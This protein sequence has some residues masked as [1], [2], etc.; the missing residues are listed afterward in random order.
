MS[1]KSDGKH[2]EEVKRGA[3]STNP[4]NSAGMKGDISWLLCVLEKSITYVRVNRWAY[5]VIGIVVAATASMLIARIASVNPAFPIV[6][7]TLVFIGMFALR[8]FPNDRNIWSVNFAR[9][10]L[11]ISVLIAIIVLIGLAVTA[12]VVLVVRSSTSDRATEVPTRLKW[13]AEN[14]SAQE[15]LLPG[16]AI[17]TVRLDA[18]AERAGEPQNATISFSIISNACNWVVLE[19]DNLV[20]TVP[21]RFADLQNSCDVVV[22]AA[23][24]LPSGAVIT[25][26]PLTIT[27]SPRPPLIADLTVGTHHACALFRNGAVQCWGGLGGSYGSLA[28]PEGLIAKKIVAGYYSVCAVTGAGGIVCWGSNESSYNETIP[29]LSAQAYEVKGIFAGYRDACVQSTTGRVYCW[30]TIKGE[31]ADLSASQGAFKSLSGRFACSIEA[32][33]LSCYDLETRRRFPVFSEVQADVVDFSEPGSRVCAQFEDKKIRCHLFGQD[34][35]VD[36]SGSFKGD[37]QQIADTDEY[38]CVLLKNG[39][40]GCSLPDQLVS[41]MGP[42]T[43]APPEN[44]RAVKL[45]PGKHW[46]M[47][48]VTSGGKIACWD[49]KRTRIFENLIPEPLRYS[50]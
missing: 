35:T 29:P 17:K 32:R 14:T 2:A 8:L 16:Q 21:F 20:G 50:P 22:R 36:V 30:G 34:Q 19:K 47:C 48:A 25:S 33:R 45:F 44:L 3:A 41:Q 49:F 40:V 28:T 46:P 43:P 39:Q 11:V 4:Q 9:H 26:D 24:L 23:G 18:Y 5:G 12:A 7:F 10:A 38:L 1:E 15:N 27:F 31:I 6:G 37:I 13:R 42:L